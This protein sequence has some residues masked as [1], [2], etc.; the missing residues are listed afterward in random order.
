M[1]GSIERRDGS[2]GISST[3]LHLSTSKVCV[4]SSGLTKINP[5]MTET[6]R[7]WAN[8]TEER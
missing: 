6:A 2:K 8:D 1:S 7:Y 4:I 5:P 3:I